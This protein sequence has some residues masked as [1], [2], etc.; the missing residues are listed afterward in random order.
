[1]DSEKS[2]TNSADMEMDGP[3]IEMAQRFDNMHWT[4]DNRVKNR[5]RSPLMKSPTIFEDDDA[6]M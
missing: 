6:E 3:T 5:I 4:T 2:I 1:M